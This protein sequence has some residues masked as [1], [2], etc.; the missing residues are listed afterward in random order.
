MENEIII[1]R[2]IKIGHKSDDYTGVTVI[3][4][5]RGCVSG[6]DVRGGAPGTRET[7]LLRPEK[8]MEKI[9]AVVLSGGSAYGLASACGVMEYMRERGIGYKIGGKVVPIVCGAVIYDLNDAE[10]HYPTAQWGY[11]AAANASSSDVEFGQA[12]VGKGATVGKIRGIRNADKSGLGAA[13]VKV[14]GNVVTAIVAVNAMGDITD[15]AGNILAGAKGRNG[16]YID[17]ARCIAEGKWLK[18]VTGANTTIGCI[19]TNAKL[20]KVEANKLASIAH[21]A[22]AKHI[23]PVHTD[24]DGDTIFSMCTGVRRP[25]NFLLLQTAA[26]EAMGKAIMNAAQGAQYKVRYAAAEDIPDDNEKDEF[27]E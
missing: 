25:L 20:T 11:E 8:A 2:G 27:H 1:P 3:T 5:E 7:D 9:N 13:S 6:V 18:L 10:Y 26:V 22:Y 24:Y 14:G 23:S 17:T 4:C 21:N 15:G 12:G 16:R 19:I